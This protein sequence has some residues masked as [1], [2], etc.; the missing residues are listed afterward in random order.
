MM[1]PTNSTQK[2]RGRIW[3]SVLF[4]L[5]SALFMQCANEY[6]HDAQHENADN[7][8][9]IECHVNG[10]AKRPK[11]FHFDGGNLNDD[12]QDCKKCH[13]MDN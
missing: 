4:L 1:A 7:A 13:K 10:S 8:K 9:C 2:V 3:L 11:D 6:P 5:M 12:H